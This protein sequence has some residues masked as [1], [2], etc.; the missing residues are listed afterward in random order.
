VRDAVIDPQ[1]LQAANVVLRAEAAY[2]SNEDLIAV[3]AY[4]AGADRLVDAAIAFRSEMLAF[5][6][7]RAEEDGSFPQARTGLVE[8]A[9]RIQGHADG[10]AA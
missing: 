4:R 1:H 3:G 2:R 7:Q 6:C 10:R 8:L 5:L 9:R